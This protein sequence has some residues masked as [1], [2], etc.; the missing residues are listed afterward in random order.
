MLNIFYDRECIFYKIRRIFFLRKEVDEITNNK[1]TRKKTQQRKNQFL[2]DY[3]KTNTE[4]FLR[5]FIAANQATA[6]TV[7]Y[8]S[9]LSDKLVTDIDALGKSIKKYELKNPIHESV[10]RLRLG[11]WLMS[12]G[13]FISGKIH[14]WEKV[15]ERMPKILEDYDFMKISLSN[16]LIFQYTIFESFLSLVFEILSELK[17]KL[18]QKEKINIDYIKLNKLIKSYEL[19]DYYKDRFYFL[20][21]IGKINDRFKKLNNYGLKIPLQEIRETIDGLEKFKAVRDIYVHNNGK[22][23][24]K[25]KTLVETNIEIDKEYPLTINYLNE[26]E[27]YITS[28]FFIL[29]VEVG[30][31]LKV[32]NDEILQFTGMRDFLKLFQT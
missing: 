29:A 18:W 32:T 7:L 20:I 5:Q 11:L 14:T 10:L 22:V 26:I 13:S 17:P 28:A 1:T 3:F 21:S 25:F 31:K 9:V 24:R 6:I 30:Q 2:W 4:N 16:E 12:G 23:N 15:S 27:D 19:E 8:T